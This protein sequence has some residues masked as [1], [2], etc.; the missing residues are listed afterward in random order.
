MRR[1]R[2]EKP[3]LLLWHPDLADLAGQFGESLLV[4]YVYDQYSGYT[5][6]SVESA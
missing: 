4:Y 6:G 5:G 1:E 3:V 2:F